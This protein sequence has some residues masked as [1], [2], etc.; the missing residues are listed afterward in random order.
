[1]VEHDDTLLLGKVALFKILQVGGDDD[2]DG[3]T[4]TA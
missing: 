3:G 4:T 1:L 2:L